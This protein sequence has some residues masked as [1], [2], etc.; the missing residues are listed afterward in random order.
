MVKYFLS[1]TA[2]CALVVL[3]NVSHAGEPVLLSKY[4][5]WG[6]YFFKESANKVCYMASQPQKKEGDYSSRGEP[7]ALVTHRPADN[8][9]NVFSY[10][11]GYTY[12]AGSTVSVMI[13][14][15]EF[16]LVTQD[17]IAWAPDSET[18]NKLADAL[19]SGSKMIIKGESSRGTETTDTLS[20]S[21]TS[22]AYEQMS[23]ECGY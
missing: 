18:D 14:D 17:G 3:P 2:L 7:F 1:F 9:R 13:D 15:T 20:L 16:T 4:G 22:K 23:E 10:I 21:G 11:T 19:K 5:D 6:A 12:K 8:T